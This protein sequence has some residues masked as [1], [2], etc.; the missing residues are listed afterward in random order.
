MMWQAILG[1]VLPALAN[2]VLNR[3]GGGNPASSVNPDGSLLPS[4]M[5]SSPQAQNGSGIPAWLGQAVSSAAPAIGQ[6][7]T[8]L[9]TARYNGMAARAFADEAY[10]GTTPWEQLGGGAGGQAM[11]AA[12]QADELRQRERESVRHQ[13]TQVSLSRMQA[14]A[15]VSQQLLQ[16]GGSAGFAAAEQI[17]RSTGILTEAGFGVDPRSLVP[18]RASADIQSSLAHAGYT[19]GPLTDETYASASANIAR[20]GLDVSQQRINDER[21]VTERLVQAEVIARTDAAQAEP[22]IRMLDIEFRRWLALLEQEPAWAS[23]LRGLSQFAGDAW[24][25]LSS[26]PFMEGGN[27]LDTQ[28]LN[29]FT[30]RLADQVGSE[31]ADAFRRFLQESQ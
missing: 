24:S 19:S 22:V 6:V 15:M 4:Q 25:D 18:G 9:G 27:S 30:S 16:D 21:V 12:S 28:L 1:A 5:P 8:R 23:R 26:A 2:R 29:F 11:Q 13:E 14:A 3:G 17:L 20:A 10:P 31:E 7:L